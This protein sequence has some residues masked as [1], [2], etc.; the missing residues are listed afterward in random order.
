MRL[1]SLLGFLAVAPCAAVLAQSQPGL[2]PE[3]PLPTPP[4]ATLPTFRS[5]QDVGPEAPLTRPGA[6]TLPS[7][8][9]QPG[10]GAEAPL[11]LPLP[12][13]ASLPSFLGQGASVS[14][15]TSP[16]AGATVIVPNGN[17]TTTIIHPDGSVETVPT[18]R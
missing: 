18:A 9:S 8:L 10:V 5:N 11:P 14:R 1:I 6:N 2:P 7:M 13:A 15:Q 3:A 12:P 4:A 16:G 17:G